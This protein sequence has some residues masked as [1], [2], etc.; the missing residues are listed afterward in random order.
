MP[1]CSEDAMPDSHVVIFHRPGPAW[2]PG[3]AFFEQRGVHEHVA[4]YR[5][6]LGASKLAMGGPFL[7]AQGGGMMIAAKGVDATELSDFAARDPAVASGLLVYE[8]RPWLVGM[9]A[10]TT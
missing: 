4:H 2:Q 3:L 5:E 9:S 1:T 7:D 10:P 8:V 6:L